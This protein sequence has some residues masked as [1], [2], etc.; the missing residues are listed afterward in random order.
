MLEWYRAE[1]PYDALIDDCATILALAAKVAG[2]GMFSFRGRTADPFAAPTRITVAESFKQYAAID[3]LATLSGDAGDRDALAKQARAANIEIAA[4]DTWSDI[5]SRIL[6]ERIEPQLG[7]G[8]ATILD[9]YPTI[10]AALARR[11][12]HDP[13]VADASSCMCGVELEC[14]QVTDRSVESSANGSRSGERRGARARRALSDRRRLWRR[15]ARRSFSI[16]LR[17]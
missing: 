5:F 17:V 2:A 6:V 7:I 9:E 1:E 16:A 8:Q 11:K 13:R 12:A 10:E 15:C 3:L 4:N 14:V